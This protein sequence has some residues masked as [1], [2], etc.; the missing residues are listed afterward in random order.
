MLLKENLAPQWNN[1]SILFIHGIGRQP[2]DFATPLYERLRAVDPELADQCLWHSVAYDDVNTAMEEKVI[3]FNVALEKEGENAMVSLGSDFMIDL[4]NFL[5]AVDPYHW[6]TNTTRKAFQE[7]VSEGVKRGVHQNEHEIYVLSHSLGTVVAYET[8][9]HILTDPQVLGLTSGFRA[10][11]LYTL[12][13]PIAFI[14][15]NESRIPS[16]ND[17]FALRE[18]PIERPMRFNKVR[19]RNESNIVEWINLRQKFDPVASLVP[20][21]V[22]ASN[23]SVNEDRVFDKFHTGANPHDFHNYLKEFGPAIMENIRG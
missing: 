4:I 17:D 18:G 20:L 22:E 13:S 14:K 9:H 12:G 2:A 10:Q 3:Q 19:K 23:Q 1:K 7:V 16:V 11:T 8:F 6:I 5:F 21:T 15:A